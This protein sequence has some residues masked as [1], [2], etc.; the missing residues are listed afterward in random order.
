LGARL[1]SETV[2]DADGIPGELKHKVLIM[3]VGRPVGGRGGREEAVEG[4]V[5]CPCLATPTSIR[6]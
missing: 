5:T 2:A 6:R 1:M 4:A 3:R